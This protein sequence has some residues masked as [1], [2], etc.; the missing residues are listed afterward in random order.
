MADVRE[1]DFRSRHTTPEQGAA[2]YTALSFDVAL[3]LRNP[4][5]RKKMPF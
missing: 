4:S 5:S 1:G 2:V 3:I